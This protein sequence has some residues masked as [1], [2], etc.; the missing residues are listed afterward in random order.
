MVFDPSYMEIDMS[1]FNQCEWHNLYGEVQEAVPPNATP[2]WVKEV[3]IHIYVDLDNSEDKI[4][5]RLGSVF[6]FY[7][8]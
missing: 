4:T 2:D 8:T 7:W 6:S 5:R 1:T 3:D